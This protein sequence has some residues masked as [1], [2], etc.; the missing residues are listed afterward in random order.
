MKVIEHETLPPI[1]QKVLDHGYVIF[2]DG[3]YDLNIVGLRNLSDENKFNQFDDR[4]F[5]VYKRGDIWVEESG[6]ATTDPGRYWLLKPDY[7]P[8]AI[9]KH[10]QQA[11]GA[12]KIGNHRGYKALTQ[13][14]RVEFWRDG[15]KDEVI[16]Y[17]GVVH[18]DVIG[19]NIHRSSTREGG[20]VYVDRW[21][22]GCQV[23]QDSR[24]FDRMLELCQLQINSLNY[25]TFT[26]TLLA[27]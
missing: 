15:N 3:D 19:L 2:E 23:W 26:Y 6:A 14:A 24:D 25:R 27:E 8:C 13:W 7:K 4:I 12:Y 11:R 17:S 9:M 10:P 22:A 1:L 5:I 18:K 20:S 16:N 21:S